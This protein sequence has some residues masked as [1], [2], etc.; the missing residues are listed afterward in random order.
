MLAGDSWVE[1][2]AELLPASK[3]EVGKQLDAQEAKFAA[4]EK[5]AAEDALAINGLQATVK[6][7]VSFL[8]RPLLH[9]LTY[10]LHSCS[11]KHSE[12]S[13]AVTSS[14]LAGAKALREFI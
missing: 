1:Q 9:P 2:T 13:A 3:R 5:T 11:L 7:L 4:L 12:E 8:V 14:C 6:V 10:F